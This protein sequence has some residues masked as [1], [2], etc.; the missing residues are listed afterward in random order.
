MRRATP[1]LVVCGDVVLAVGTE[2]ERA[3]ALAIADGRVVAAGS[4]RDVLPLAGAATRVIDAG[5]AAVIPGL[6]DFHIHLVGLARTRADVT[7]DD[8]ADAHEIG[9]RIRAHLGTLAADAWLTGRGWNEAQLAVGL[10][11]VAEAVGERLAY[12]SSHDGHSAWASPAALRRA[13]ITASSPDPEGGRIERD[14]DRVP[15]GVLRETALELVDRLVPR[16]SGAALAP[17]LSATLAELA[18]F[19]ITGASEAGDYTAANGIGP[20]AA[21]GDSFSTLT[22]LA[23]ILDGRLRMSIGIP[24]EA[25][26]AATQRGLRTGVALDGRRTLRMGWA[27]EYADGALGSGTAALFEPSTCGARDTGIL[28]VSDEQ[29]DALFATARPAGIGLAI[30]AI[31]DRATAS[32]LDAAQRATPRAPGCPADRMEH[33]QLTRA[34]D[35]QRIARLGVVASIQPIHAAA[36]RDLVD[37]CWADRTADAYAWRA[38]VEAGSLL[39]AGSD[40]PVESVDPW[41]GT[42]AAVHRRGPDD[43]R[44]DWMSGEALRLPEALGAYT[45]GPARAIGASD[46]GHLRPG[47]RADVAVLDAPLEAVLAAD[48]RLVQVRSTLTLVDGAIVHEG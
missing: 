29:L 3:E 16:L 8:A 6:H 20:D 11:P 34:G 48:E 24:A 4:R 21:L 12:L 36:D 22:S 40:A 31:G 26:P 13:G 14:A 15:T 25:L 33:L 23:A 41:L 27:K 9:V 7:L 17:H 44:G 30:H 5:P 19:G 42:F 18:R 46:E 10:A 39:A 32:V 47:A 28:R 43:R 1:N 37:S 35:R 2:M 45:L 38:L